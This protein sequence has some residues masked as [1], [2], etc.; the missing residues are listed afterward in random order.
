MAR[1]PITLDELLSVRGRLR[2]ELPSELTSNHRQFL[3]GLVVGEPDRHLMTCRHLVALPA[4]PSKL[5][6]LAKLK[7]A[8]LRIF[9][10]QDNELRSRF[11][12]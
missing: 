6:N 7:K 10:Q 9:A 1:E 12:V 2:E 5:H 11:G 8:N 4:I 3:L